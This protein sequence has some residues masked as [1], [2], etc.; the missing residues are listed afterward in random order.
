[1]PSLHNIAKVPIEAK[2][3]VVDLARDGFH[4]GVESHK[5]MAGMILEGIKNV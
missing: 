4:P 5:I 3:T 2:E 1:M